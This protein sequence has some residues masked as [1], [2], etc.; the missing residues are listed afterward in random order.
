MDRSDI[1]AANDLSG[2]RKEFLITANEDRISGPTGSRVYDLD[3]MKVSEYLRIKRHPNIDWI[4][5]RDDELS[6]R[7]V[8][9]FLPTD[10]GKEVEKF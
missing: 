4:V 10:R 7:L 5:V 6:E 9:E 3:K 2:E 1:V 8:A